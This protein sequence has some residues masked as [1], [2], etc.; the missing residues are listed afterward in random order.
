[1]DDTIIPELNS[2]KVLRFK[3]DSF[4]TW[5]PQTIDILGRAIGKVRAN[6]IIAIPF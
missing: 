4:L 5:E 6:F 2:I 3:F 1:M